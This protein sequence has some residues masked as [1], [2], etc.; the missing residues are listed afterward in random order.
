MSHIPGKTVAD[1]KAWLAGLATPAGPAGPPPFVSSGGY[2]GELPG[3]GW[4]KLDAEPGNYVA[5]CLIPDDKTGFPHAAMGMV[6]GFTV[7]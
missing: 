2:G 7:N 3:G 1:A 5:F 6:V 4:L